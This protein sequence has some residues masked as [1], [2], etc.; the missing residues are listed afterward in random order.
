MKLNWDKVE[1]RK[2]Q[3]KGGTWKHPSDTSAVEIEKWLDKYKWSVWNKK[4]K[5]LNA[6][7]QLRLLLQ[8]YTKENSDNSS[9]IQK[10]LK[11]RSKQVM[12]KFMQYKEAM[13]WAETAS[14]DEI[15]SSYEMLTTFRAFLESE[16]SVE[17]LEFIEDVQNRVTRD[18]IMKKYIGRRAPKQINISSGC[19]NA[20]EAG[21]DFDDAVH[22]VT[23][24]FEKDSLPRYR[25]SKFMEMALNAI[26]KF[27]GLG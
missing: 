3:Q 9:E 12:K 2:D 27:N 8:A 5:K 24:L 11:R 25:K 22:E 17:N 13:E 18:T 15:K 4:E 1:W 16:F 23:R 19:L 7:K 6:L 10:I 26:A 14:W 21:G 20:I